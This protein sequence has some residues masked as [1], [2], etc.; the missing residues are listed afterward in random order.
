MLTFWVKD[1]EARKVYRDGAQ[2]IVDGRDAQ[3]L[4]GQ[5][6]QHPAD[7]QAKAE[8]AAA[9]ESIPPSSVPCC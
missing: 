2:T 6:S 9:H 5:L 1:P 3:L 4:Q 8:A 7:A